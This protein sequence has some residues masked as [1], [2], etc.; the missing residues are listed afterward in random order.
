[1]KKFS[2]FALI[3]TIS[4]ALI[5][6]AGTSQSC[7]YKFTESQP[8]PDSIKTV[9]VEIIENRAPYQNPQLSPAL[10]DRLRQKIVNQTKLSQTNNDNAHMLIRGTITDYSVSTSGITSSGGRSET[11][12]NRLTVTVNVVLI[13]QLENKPEESYTVTRQFDFRST[14]S[15]QQ[16]EAGLLDEM[17]RNLTDEIF[18]SIFSKW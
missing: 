8:L 5:A 13:R 6:V 7:T 9:K 15:L 16:A 14:Q 11:S 17:V 18:N 2:G 12:I 1:M 3:L 10:T 4:I